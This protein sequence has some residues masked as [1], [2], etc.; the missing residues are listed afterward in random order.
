MPIP[1]GCLAHFDAAVYR[2]YA[3]KIVEVLSR[4]EFGWTGPAMIDGPPRYC[5][6]RDGVPATVPV[7]LRPLI[8]E[9]P[10]VKFTA[11][12][13]HFDGYHREAA[14]MQLLDV[15]TLVSEDLGPERF[16]AATAAHPWVAEFMR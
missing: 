11:V 1:T 12:L 13:D 7:D 6:L 9:P 4:L 14:P 16:A 2:P 15:L 5:L 3:R 10:R 8:P